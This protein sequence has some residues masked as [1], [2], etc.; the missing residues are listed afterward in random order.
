MKN[1]ETLGLI[2]LINESSQ[3]IRGF[4]LIVKFLP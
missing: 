1:I 2:G 3:K 4:R